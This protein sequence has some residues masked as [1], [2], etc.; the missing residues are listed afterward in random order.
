MMLSM[1][2]NMT[3]YAINNTISVGQVKFTNNN[4]IVLKS[5][6]PEGNTVYFS[7]EISNHSSAVTA[8]LCIIAIYEDNVLTNTNCEYVDIDADKKK[9]ISVG[10]LVPNGTN[11]S[12]SKIVAY[13]WDSITGT[14]I[15]SSEA[16]FLNSTTDLEGIL[17]GNS[18]LDSYSDDVDKYT[19]KVS[20]DVSIVPVVSDQTTK[21]EVSDYE[22]PGEATITLTPAFISE[23][24]PIRKIKISL[25]QQES[26]TYTLSTL[27]YILDGKEYEIPD[28]VSNVLDYE[29]ELP[30]NTFFVR[31]NGI[32][33]GDISYSAQDFYTNSGIV[34]DGVNYGQLDSAT[35]GTAL[36]TIRP[37]NDE[38]IIPIKNE[39]TV[40]VAYVTNGNKKTKYS[41][42]FISKQPRLTSFKM[43]DNA[44][45]DSF[46]PTFIGGA[47]LYKDNGSISFSDRRWAF[48]YTSKALLGA[49]YFMGV[50]S[51]NNSNWWFTGGKAG[52][53]Y[54]SFTADTAG[55]VVFMVPSAGNTY[56]VE[57][58]YWTRENKDNSP[59][60]PYD[61]VYVGKKDWNDYDTPVYYSYALGWVTDTARTVSPWINSL[62]SADSTLA[63]GSQPLDTAY[64]R[65][66]EAGETVK[67][68]HSGYTGFSGAAS[69]WAILWDVDNQVYNADNFSIEE[70]ED[71]PTD[72]TNP[73]AEEGLV[74]K[75]LSEDN[76]GDGYYDKSVDTWKDLSGKDNN[77]KLYT[78]VNNY[79]T[80]DGFVTTGGGSDSSKI[81]YLPSAVVNTINTYD[82]SIEFVV[83][84]IEKLGTRA[85][86][87]YSD[88][89]NFKIS[90]ESGSNATFKWADLVYSK[91]TVDVNTV[92]GSTNTITVSTKNKMVCWYVDGVLMDSKTFSSSSNTANNIMLNYYNDKYNASVTFKSIKV[93]DFAFTAEEVANRSNG[94]TATSNLLTENILSTSLNSENENKII[95]VFGT[96]ADRTLV[97]VV[98]LNPGYEFSDLDKTISDDGDITDIVAYI[99]QTMTNANGAFT[100]TITLPSSAQMGEYRVMGGSNITTIYYA[101]LVD[102]LKMVK[103]IRATNNASE[104]QAV[105]DSNHEYFG[106]N[107][108][109]YNILSNT[110]KISEICYNDIK[111]AAIDET[112]E[113]S[114]T[115]LANI[116]DGAILMTM[117][118]DS[119]MSE[120]ES[121]L[122]YLDKT[123]T[124]IET[125]A[126]YDDISDDGKSQIIKELIG[127]NYKNIGNLNEDFEK[128]LALQAINY[129]SEKTASAIL[130][131]ITQYSDLLDLDISKFNNLSQSNKLSVAVLLSNSKCMLSNMQSTLDSLVSNVQ[132]SDT[133]TVSSN[134][135]KSTSGVA[136]FVASSSADINKEN[137][138]ADLGNYSWAKA[139]IEGLTA[140]G[141]ISGYEN[142]TFKPENNITRSEFATII[143]KKFLK[144]D[145][146]A[147]T[148]FSDVYK[149]NWFYPYVI[150][151]YNN[152]IVKGVGD[153]M[154]A[155]TVNITRQDMAV[156]LLRIAEK[157]GVSLERSNDIFADD[158]DIADYAKNAVY[159]LKNIGVVNGMDGGYFVP[160]AFASRAEAAQMLYNFVNAISTED[161][162]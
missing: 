44:S 15:Y 17:I 39:S 154:F 1:L 45:S 132:S 59:T 134:R 70:N 64:S 107:S 133:G 155:P 103:D 74:M 66:F 75:L 115:T 10:V 33:A 41:V 32:S 157:Y 20:G 53:E 5:F 83:N 62:A 143:A 50:Y 63:S 160:K 12:N 89:G 11:T 25:Y 97:K 156:M 102:R 121:Y 8:V 54:F 146:N 127:N 49:S 18:W 110:L 7:T 68:Y 14:E 13:V 48:A 95:D 28:F 61:S 37:T 85:A 36:P 159:M 16:V 93:Y 65:K 73:Y 130:N 99:G 142:G 108:S 151:V 118:N 147:D 21:A 24:T 82:Y 105:I 67:V 149:Q 43:S 152:G 22:I 117:F 88:N 30:D 94:I 38:G 90:Q 141:V 78:D 126:L 87:L 69:M 111:N 26:D 129:P 77:M 31:L 79:W 136:P 150:A 106:I 56:G 137:A 104:L 158:E 98:A 135:T 109:L 86:I 125:I 9:D 140:D 100:K 60:I 3:I 46:K 131:H 27:S 34:V 162:K 153:G 51:N 4:G 144:I 101:S 40:G 23:E 80:T 128:Q 6:P 84:K 112:D 81:S 120:L 72:D 35:A 148:C 124:R 122:E 161:T 139:A 123:D 114:I 55:T 2:S 113:S 96:G 29:V 116:I 58:D 138:F 52:D 71:T 57:G 42:T 19:V 91:P 76:S 92:V 47:G 145:S 119:S